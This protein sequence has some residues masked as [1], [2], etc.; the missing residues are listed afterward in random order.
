MV[1]ELEGVEQVWTDV[2]GELQ[3]RVRWISEFMQA[4]TEGERERKAAMDE[5]LYSSLAAM[6]DVAHLSDG[7]SSAWWSPKPWR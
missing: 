7:G 3:E 1:L 2:R 4:L 5:L 6:L